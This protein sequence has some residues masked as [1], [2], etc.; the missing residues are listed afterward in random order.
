MARHL[1]QRLD[2]ARLADAARRRS[3]RAPSFRGPHRT[4]SHPAR[5]PDLRR[6]GTT[7]PSGMPITHGICVRMQR[8]A[9]T[10][11]ASCF[12]WPRR[13]AWAII[14]PTFT[15]INLALM[16]PARVFRSSLRSLAARVT[17]TRR[18][19]EVKISGDNLASSLARQLQT[20]YLVSGD[21]PLLVNEAADAIRATARQPGIRGARAARHRA[22]LR[23]AGFARRQPRDVAVRSAQD[24]RDSHGECRA[25]RAGRGCNRRAGGATFARHAGADHRGASSTAA[26]RARAG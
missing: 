4:T 21:E 23:L 24:R 13:A 17:A 2:D 3:A 25:G 8:N 1:A 14:G 20:I 5:S 19:P 10:G 12:L 6:R 22:R 16:T 9:A 11:A 7:R 26:R 18:A 15:R